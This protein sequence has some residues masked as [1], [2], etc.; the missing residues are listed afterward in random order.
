MLFFSGFELY[1]R[2]VPLIGVGARWALILE[3]FTPES[4]TVLSKPHEV[5]IIAF[6]QCVYSSASYM[7]SRF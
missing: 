3:K 7:Y 5:M 2:W 6:E 1:S 4:P